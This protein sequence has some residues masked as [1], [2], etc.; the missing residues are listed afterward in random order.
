MQDRRVNLTKRIVDAAKPAT[1]DYQIW[2]AKVRGFGVRVYPSGVK[3]FVLQYRNSARAD[4]QDCAWSLWNS[5][6]GKGPG[7]GHQAARGYR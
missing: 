7:E 5:H 6:R 2:D 1:E 3:A 4:A